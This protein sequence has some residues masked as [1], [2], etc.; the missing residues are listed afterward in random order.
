MIILQIYQSQ[1]QDCKVIV[2]DAMVIVQRIANGK[3]SKEI[4]T[5]EDFS[6]SFV[7][8]IKRC[9]IGYHEWR[10]VFDDYYETSLQNNTRKI[11]GNTTT[12][13]RFLI[14]DRTLIRESH[15]IFLSNVQT[16]RDFT[17]YLATKCR[18]HFENQEI[19]YLISSNSN[20]FG[21][22]CQDIRHNHEEADTNII[23]HCIIHSSKYNANLAS[24]VVTCNTDVFCL[25]V[26][27]HHKM[28]QKT[29]MKTSTHVIDINSITKMLD[30][31]KSLSL[32]SVH[33]LSGCDTTGR[34]LKK[35]KSKWFSLFMKI[36]KQSLESSEPLRFLSKL[37][38]LICNL[39]CNAKHINTLK[40]ARYYL[41]F[42][43]TRR[44]PPTTASSKQ[45]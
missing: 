30:L 40:D 38:E 42:L 5:C 6:N 35:G 2:I 32:A 19:Q 28:S 20:T 33:A 9:A 45:Y 25:L 12:Q 17:V 14:E 3:M 27:F 37:E 36:E 44:L 18:N 43:D 29:Y 41:Y 39:Y 16:K 13:N 26:R 22:I 34:F 23:Q 21:N 15:K 7:E 4:K 11:R 24:T 10:I 8:T 1:N 31:V